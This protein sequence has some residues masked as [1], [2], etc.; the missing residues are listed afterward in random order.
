MQERSGK[1]IKPPKKAGVTLQLLDYWVADRF[2]VPLLHKIGV[3]LAHRQPPGLAD[4]LCLLHTGIYLYSQL[5][6]ANR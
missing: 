5:Q 4:R 6:L 2:C 1:Q 3:Q